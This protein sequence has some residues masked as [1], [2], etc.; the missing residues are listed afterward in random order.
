MLSAHG[1]STEGE[2]VVSTGSYIERA[3]AL[4]FAVGLGVAVATGGT[5]LASADSGEAAGAQ[6]DTHSEPSEPS[7]RPNAAD[8]APAPESGD[9]SDDTEP[10]DDDTDGT[11]DLGDEA[12]EP[13]VQ[14]GVEDDDIDDGT[15]TTSGAEPSTPLEQ[16]A[17]GDLVQD[18]AAE[19]VAL[20]PGGQPPA[21]TQII[22][23]DSHSAVEIVE[24]AES[25]TP[26]AAE[27]AVSHE[28]SSGA[29]DHDAENLLESPQSAAGARTTAI[30]GAAETV[31]AATL[32]ATVSAPTVAP[33]KGL[34]PR[35]LAMVG[36]ALPHVSLKIPTTPA[37]PAVLVGM[38]DWVRRELDRI[39][40]N[41]RPTPDA[42]QIVQGTGTGVIVGTFNTTDE[43]NDRLTFEVAEKPKYGD[44]VVFSNGTYVYTPNA[45]VTPEQ[46]ASGWTDA[47]SVR[48]VD[49][50]LSVRTVTDFLTGRS[51][52]VKLAVGVDVSPY[53]QVAQPDS[54]LSEG[55]VMAAASDTVTKGFDVINASSRPVKLIAY[56]DHLQNQV[57]QSPHVG[58]ILQPGETHHF[59][60]V[61]YFL[62]EGR[63]YPTY[64]VLAPDGRVDGQWSLMMRVGAFSETQSSCSTSG[65]AVCNRYGAPMVLMDQPGGV[66]EI[67]A[68]Q[69][70]KQAEALNR[71]CGGS[72]PATCSFEAKKQERTYGKEREIW[73]YQ[74]AETKAELKDSVKFS[75]STS[76]SVEISATAGINIKKIVSAEISTKYSAKFEE[77][78]ETTKTIAITVPPW[79]HKIQVAE[80]P[81][82][83]YTGDFTVKMG[84]TTY[85]LRD[86]YFD[87]P[88][89]DRAVRYREISVPI[90]H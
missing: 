7:P 47:F 13:G 49:R 81:V 21:A 19:I 33:A 2:R 3:G 10:G 85:F 54:P 72:A 60:V 28:S 66:V 61:Y 78:V 50:G 74:T 14:D 23:R 30:A 43:E 84:N 17:A 24:E 67:P 69:G 46:M 68:G 1:P 22:D 8:E 48:I 25:E 12:A 77:T 57:T 70:Q 65:A 59:E 90:A 89:P 44:V 40:F 27:S 18:P 35:L 62:G 37:A 34:I 31:G 6:T 26:S 63:V 51:P 9:E 64:G 36:L 15:G 88:D 52:G 20:E 86:V 29:E 73:S 4:A 79:T 71:L 41:D 38:L 42:R 83:R 39:F 53:D 45:D 58:A 16:S 55:L 75:N 56:G 5:G 76:H 32:A 87:V 80:P 82:I 11:D